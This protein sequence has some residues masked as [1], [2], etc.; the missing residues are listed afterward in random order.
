MRDI[1]D[2]E[3]INN[4]NLSLDYIRAEIEQHEAE[5]NRKVRKAEFIDRGDGTSLQRF[6]Y[7]PKKFD[8]IRRITGYLVGTLDR[9]ND[10]KRHEVED[11]VKHSCSS[12]ESTEGR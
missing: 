8:R 9:F 1:S 6:W 11:R 4:D 3:I 10:A 12:C 7:Y 2:I 5:K